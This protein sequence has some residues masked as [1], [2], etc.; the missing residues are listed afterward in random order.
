MDR[1]RKGPPWSDSHHI[2]LQHVTTDGRHSRESGRQLQGTKPL[3]RGA[4]GGAQ[5][6]PSAP[7]SFLAKEH[8]DSDDLPRARRGV[9][10]LRP[11]AP[12]VVI[13]DS[14]RMSRAPWIFG[15]GP[16]VIVTP[17]RR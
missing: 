13:V 5:G 7:S 14:K 6:T 2:R 8:R 4:L 15:G 12:D 3:S 1:P 10:E 11:W 17:L 16:G 9:R